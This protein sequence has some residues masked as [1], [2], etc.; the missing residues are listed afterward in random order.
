MRAALAFSILLSS[1]AALAQQ[2][3]S[4]STA[5]AQLLYDEAR[6]E[7]SRG[8]YA[9]AC[10]KLEA[11]KKLLPMH[12]RT[13]ITLADCYLGAD[14]P[15]TAA[16]TLRDALELAQTQG[17]EQKIAEIQN[18]L[19]SVEANT[20]TL[21]VVVPRHLLRFDGFSTT[22]NGY[23]LPLAEWEKP[24]RVDY[25]E[26]TIEASAKGM[27]P[28]ASSIKVEKNSQKEY[29]VVV[30]PDWV[31]PDESKEEKREPGEEEPTATPIPPTPPAPPRR[32]RSRHDTGAENADAQGNSTMRVLG[33]ATMTLGGLGVASGLYFGMQA[34]NQK[35]ASDADG[36]C[37]PNDHCDQIGY[38]LRKEAVSLANTS[39]GFV[40]VGALAF[41]GGYWMW[42][43]SG[44]SLQKRVS[45]QGSRF[46]GVGPGRVF[47]GG[48]F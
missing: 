48:T 36:H 20:P 34:I 26:V 47:L 30:K 1:G 25:G 40:I 3:D 4:S 42:R 17:E 18:K 29:R 12:L 14:K 37:L 10:P 13:R 8:D 6:K 19:P 2:G 31:L 32:G 45:A 43:S 15:A 46:L 24:I 5:S 16:A 41:G 33:I 44:P 28:W 38:D 9:N 39:T 23:A 22:R 35:D 21:T 27:V 7:M 11:A